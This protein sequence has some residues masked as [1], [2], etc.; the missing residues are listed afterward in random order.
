MVRQL[1]GS[2]VQ[3]R[4]Q[5][6]GTRTRTLGWVFPD[7]AGRSNLLARSSYSLNPTSTLPSS[8]H[9]QLYDNGDATTWQ[10]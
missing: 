5:H 1:H 2:Q 3:V 8:S 6:V 4:V 7:M 10:R 9:A